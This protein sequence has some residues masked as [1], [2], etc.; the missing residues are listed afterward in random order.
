MVHA[1]AR[2]PSL[3]AAARA[4]GTLGRR[5]GLAGILRPVLLGGTLLDAV[6]PGRRRCDSHRQDVPYGSGSGPWLSAA[7]DL[8]GAAPA[9]PE[10]H[11]ALPD[12]PP[13]RPLASGTAARRGHLV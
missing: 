10:R 1:A 13:S 12:G 3:A 6:G 4:R 11:A 9:R 5:R 7:P 2:P 8:L